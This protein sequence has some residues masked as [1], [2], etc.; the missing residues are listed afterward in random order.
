MWT[1]LT[2]S[3]LPCVGVGVWTYMCGMGSGRVCA[4][5]LLLYMYKC[6]NVIHYIQLFMVACKTAILSHGPMELLATFTCALDMGIIE[7]H[8]SK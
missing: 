7:F 3:A 8:W 1:C 5:V 6:S 2:R 4:C